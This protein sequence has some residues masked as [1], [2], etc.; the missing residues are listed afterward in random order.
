M[1]SIAPYC[2]TLRGSSAR[3][4]PPFR[5]GFLFATGRGAGAGTCPQHP[6]VLLPG[7]NVGLSQQVAT[8]PLRRGSMRVWLES[9]VKRQCTPANGPTTHGIV[10]DTFLIRRI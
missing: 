6:Q 5:G 10:S 3:A 2:F 1:A 8:G 4:G 9:K 7:L